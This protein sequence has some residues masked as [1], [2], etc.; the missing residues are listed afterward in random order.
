M[1]GLDNLDSAA[2]HTI[3]VARD[4][5]RAGAERREASRIEFLA[6]HFQFPDGCL[7]VGKTHVFGPVFGR[8]CQRHADG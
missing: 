2:T 3:A 4:D 1:R 6:R 7:M 5:S 8:E